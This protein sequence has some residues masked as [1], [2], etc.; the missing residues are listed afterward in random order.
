[1]TD[2]PGTIRYVPLDFDLRVPCTAAEM[3][4]LEMV[5]GPENEGNRLVADF[6]VGESSQYVRVDFPHVEIVRVIDEVYIPLE[7]AAAKVVGHIAGHFAYR[8]VG[9]SFWAPQ[10]EAFQVYL[11]GSEHYLFVTG[12]SCLDVISRFEPSISWVTPI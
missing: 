12:G 10:R 7:E 9:S 2:N 4:R 6:S 5:C 11:P 1:M 8:I 3:Y